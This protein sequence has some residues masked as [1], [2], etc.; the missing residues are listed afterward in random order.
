[1]KSYSHIYCFVPVDN[2]A[3]ECERLDIDNMNVAFLGANVQPFALKRKMNEGDP[4]NRKTGTPTPVFLMGFPV[5]YLE[6]LSEC[7]RIRE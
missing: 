6:S 1:M 3:R 5:L 4:E 7:L 2:V